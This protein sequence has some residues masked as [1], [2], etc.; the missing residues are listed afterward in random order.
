MAAEVVVVPFFGQGHL[1]PSIDLCKRLSSLK[2]KVVFIISSNL[3]SSIPGPLRDLPL[4][5]IV[6]IQSTL[7]P[8]PPT[9]SI[10]PSTGKDADPME[11]H[12]HHHGQLS[13]GIE[14]YLSARAEV[15]CP[16]RNVFAVV[17]V[18]M[19]WAGKL[20]AKHRVPTVGFFTSGA[21]SAALEFAMWK[22]G[23]VEIKPGEIRPLS[24]LPEDMTLTE[25]DMKRRPHGPPHL[26]DGPKGPGGPPGKGFPR[27]PGGPGPKFMGPPKPG[28]QPPWL[29]ETGGSVALMFNTCND[30]EGPF[31]E[32][33]ADQVK[34]P[35][36][37][38]GPLLPENYWK[39]SGS[40]L[41]DRDTRTNRLSSVPED[42]VIQWLNQ[43]PRGSV[44]YVAFGS[45]VGPTIEEY[46]QLAAALE[47]S[48][49]PFIWAIQPGAGRSGPPMWPRSE[50]GDDDLAGYFPT[51]LDQR[52]GERGLIIHGWAPQLLILSHPSTGGF[53][54]HC[55]WNSTVEAIGRGVPFL[56][57][58]IRGD[59]YYNAKLLIN[60]LKVGFAVSEDMSRM[61]KTDYVVKG[62]ERLMS[63]EGV[64]DRAAGLRAS[65]E[66]GFPASS[67]SSLDEFAWFVNR[68]SGGK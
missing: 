54:S 32:Y 11:G 46:P 25:W 13:E 28:Q 57:W 34:K 31:I 65:F 53:L 48:N 20:F 66:H 16:D 59:Q 36:W 6:E 51:G 29:E 41:H 52:V 4:L 8:P 35:V 49:H 9:S 61:I 56:T 23:S 67:N 27:P 5:E 2:F 10:L 19:G 44:L 24:G 62:I 12:S 43:K 60:H 64:K 14:K 18:M 15:S 33:L 37:G 38:V 50:P 1:L 63:D 42:D 68:Q 7:P 22:A 3:S 21:C 58:P 47:E 40:L 17:D 30:L 45:E 55:G 26:R 39:S